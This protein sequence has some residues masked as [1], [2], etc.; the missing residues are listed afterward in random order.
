MTLI[1]T[2]TYNPPNMEITYYKEEQREST[3]V[4]TTTVSFNNFCHTQYNCSLQL[5]H[6]NSSTQD[7]SQTVIQT[8]AETWLNA[9]GNTVQHQVLAKYIAFTENNSSTH[10]IKP[11][12]K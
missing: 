9:L 8:D 2:Y 6:Y 1:E 12:F 5:E 11:N 3:T 10:T 7:I 4:Y